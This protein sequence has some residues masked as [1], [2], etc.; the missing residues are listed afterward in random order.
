MNCPTTNGQARSRAIHRTFLYYRINKLIFIN[1]TE[2]YTETL[3]TSKPLQ[4]RSDAMFIAARVQKKP[5][6]RRGGMFIFMIYKT[7]QKIPKLTPIV[8]IIAA[9]SRASY[10]ADLSVPQVVVALPAASTAKTPS[11]P[12]PS[13][14]T[15]APESGT[16]KMT[17]S[18]MIPPK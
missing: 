9:L 10:L 4:S 16:L 5:K 6:P 17:I 18:S 12:L 7:P 1:R 3:K 11:I 13:D 14:L 2:F 8:I 15:S